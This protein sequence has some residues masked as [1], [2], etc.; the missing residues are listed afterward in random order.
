MVRPRSR[1]RHAKRLAAALGATFVAAGAMAYVTGGA[2]HHRDTEAAGGPT[3][4][5]GNSGGGG[6]SAGTPGNSS[7]DAGGGGGGGGDVA[8]YGSGGAPN[9]GLQTLV[10]GAPTGVFGPG[11]GQDGAIAGGLMPNGED[12][13][14]ILADY[15]QSHGDDGLGGNANNNSDNTPGLPP[16]G[17]GGDAGGAGGDT[18]D[19]TPPA[20]GA[21][22]GGSSAGFGL[23]GGVGGGVGGG[24]GL[25]GGAPG[26]GSSGGTPSPGN[27]TAPATT[28]VTIV[29]GG[30]DTPLGL[31][32]A[33]GPGGPTVCV[34]SALNTCVQPP[35]GG[36]PLP[37]SGPPIPTPTGGNNGAAVPGPVPE[38][39]AWLL[40]IVGFAGAGGA[41]RLQR[42]QARQALA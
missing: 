38:P 13:L 40:M 2:Q 42:R 17:F 37:I 29:G 31:P 22:Q 30:D 3:Q 20:E 6:G 39:A 14:M 36:G 18:P 12:G 34:I 16:G 1:S 19:A 21:P 26:G 28:P 24:G 32:G 25:G 4:V 27:F 23:G 41:L 35:T 8:A 11:D 15:A 5:A 33:A 9:G 7:G 10:N